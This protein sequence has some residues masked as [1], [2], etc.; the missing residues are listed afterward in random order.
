MTAALL[1]HPAAL[2][3]VVF[4]HEDAEFGQ[5]TAALVMT[6]EADEDRLVVDLR[7]HCSALVAGFKVP[8]MWWFTRRFPRDEIGKL[9]QTS[10]QRLTRAIPGHRTLA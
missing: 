7:T 8:R 6:E 3:T 4:G 10:V 1:R 9:R 2:D 5:I